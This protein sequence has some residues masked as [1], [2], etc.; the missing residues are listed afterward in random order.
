MSTLIL[1]IPTR[2][3]D[4]EN[5]ADTVINLIFLW[6]SDP[7]FNNYQILPDI[8]QLSDHT[9]LCVTMNIIKED[10]NITWQMIPKDSDKEVNCHK[11]HLDYNSGNT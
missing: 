7:G 6:S 10:I 4:N 1:Q 5:D 8:Q 9:P 3:I 11:L 2:Y